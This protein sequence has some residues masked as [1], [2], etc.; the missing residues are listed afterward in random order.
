MERPRQRAFATAALVAAAVAALSACYLLAFRDGLERLSSEGRSRLAIYASSLR[1][2]ISR[3]DYLP[4]VLATDRDLQSLLHERDDPSLVEKL[5]RRLELIGEF[6]AAAQIYILDAKG[7]ARAT[8][9]WNTPGSLIGEE[10]SFRP[11]FRDALLHGRGRHFSVGVTTGAPGYFL[12][13]PL[14]NGTQ[15]IGVIV[16]KVDLEPLEADWSASTDSVALTDENGVIFLTNV[17]NWKYRP[18]TP[19]PE[20]VLARLRESRQY[21]ASSLSPVSTVD[22]LGSGDETIPLDVPGKGIREFR[23]VSMPIPELGWTLRYMV[24]VAQ[25]RIRAA[26][27]TTLAGVTLVALLA[28]LAAWRQRV[29]RLREERD[30]QRML[31]FRI[32]QRT[33]ELRESNRRLVAE[34]LERQRAADALAAAQEEVIQAGKLSA[35]GQMAA[36]ICHEINQPISA[37]RTFA[38]S[39]QRL[40]EQKEHGEVE[41][42]LRNI[43]RLAQKMTT[44]TSHL[45]SFARKSAP[46]RLEPV[47]VAAITAE[48]LTLLA[49]RI[50]K[51]NVRVENVIDKAAIVEAEPVRLEQVMINLITN[52]LDAMETSPRRDLVLSSTG[53]EDGWTIEVIDTGQG[54]DAEIARLMFEPFFTTKK[55]G[56]GLGL[57]LALA[58]RIVREFGGRLSARRNSD[59]GTT[60]SIMLPSRRKE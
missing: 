40:A 39:G 38:K 15:V 23:L 13:S 34:M 18:L 51:E 26:F 57:G 14:R 2:K 41:A 60:M 21:G 52:A 24:P 4:A 9:N 22:R 7:V 42:V 20:S 36:A 11:Y 55:P 29:L 12:A 45:R 50:R 37:V 17:G 58:A 8:S 31:E 1:N 16:V 47:N 25:A 30:H 28:L 33:Q 59:G 53:T 3:F 44:T 54:I 32:D 49:S 46:G 56:K 43:E 19:L 48:A 5:N 10:Y 35:L 6:S 27:V